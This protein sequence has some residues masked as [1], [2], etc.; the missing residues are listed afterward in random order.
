MDEDPSNPTASVGA[1]EM[2][3]AL[4]TV[5]VQADRQREVGAPVTHVCVQR[6]RPLPVG[7]GA[8]LV[9]AAHPQGAPGFASARPAHR[10]PRVHGRVRFKDPAQPRPCNSLQIFVTIP[11]SWP[12]NIVRYFYLF[13]PPKLSMKKII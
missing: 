3:V 10:Q 12:K 5:T 4:G 1:A 13:F 11:G 2:G 7:C 6:N 8:C 9:P